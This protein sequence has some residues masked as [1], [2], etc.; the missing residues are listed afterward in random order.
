M[1]EHHILVLCFTVCSIS[2]SY[3][4][5]ESQHNPFPSN[6][7]PSMNF[8]TL[9]VN[10]FSNPFGEKDVEKNRGALPMITDTKT[11]EG[12]PDSGLG[13]QT[14]DQN[15]V[16]RKFGSRQSWRSRFTKTGQISPLLSNQNPTSQPGIVFN[17]IANPFLKQKPVT[18][19]VEEK[20]KSNVKPPP[21]THDVY[22]TPDVQ[23]I[24]HTGGEIPVVPPIPATNNAD[25][26]A[27]EFEFGGESFMVPCQW[28]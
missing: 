18:P 24:G 3:G 5:F 12:R 13:P 11:P 25:S 21:Q 22:P 7:D 8:Y 28:A 14:A 23:D 9:K 26:I 17:G 10:L 6:D 16:R 27:D 2:F 15:G 4:Q 20:P 19:T 1:S